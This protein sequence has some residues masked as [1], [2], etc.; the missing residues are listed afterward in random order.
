MPRI[1]R[2]HKDAKP[3]ALF[4]VQFRSR[5]EAYVACT[6]TA[7]GIKWEYEKRHFQIN[8]KLIYLPDFWCKY[9]GDYFWWE[10]KPIKPRNVEVTKAKGLARYTKLPVLVS[11]SCPFFS[12][13]FK[14]VMYWNE[15]HKDQQQIGLVGDF[16]GID[17]PSMEGYI[18]EAR[19]I[20]RNASKS[21]GTTP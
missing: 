5:L 21:A 6:M 7:I 14:A 9:R 18:L 8:R 12:P 4:G 2:S 15:N 11:A 16:I 1:P 20:Y 3:T 19:E 17:S 13:Q 10:V